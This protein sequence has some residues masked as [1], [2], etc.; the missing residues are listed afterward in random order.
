MRQPV[1]EVTVADCGDAIER[2]FDEG[3]TDGLPVVPPTEPLVVAFLAASGWD[4][5]EVLLREPVRGI[6]VPASAVVVNAVMAG[7][8]P[9]YL[10]VIAAALRAMSHP[11]FRLHIP[12][13][14]TGGAA[15][16]LVVNGPV[17]HAIGLN[18]GGNLFGPGNRANATIGRAI[19][20]VLRNCIGAIPGRFDH[21]TQGWF[22]KYTACIAERE[23]ASPWAPLHVRRGLPADVSAVTVLATESGHNV[24]TASGVDADALL[25]TAGD[26]VRSLG[27]H[28]DGQA[29]LVVGPEH[30][31]ILAAAELSVDDL[32]RRLFEASRRSVAE[33]KRGGRLE[34]PVD[35]GDDRRS[36][37]RG[38]TP[39]DLL[40][41]VGGGDAGCSSAWFPT[42]SRG[43]GSVAVTAPLD[44]RVSPPITSVPGPADAPGRGD[45]QPVPPR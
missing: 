33:L 40:I 16:V 5:E 24:H 26:V 18:G 21:A 15:P 6:D 1:V 8:R 7:C 31:N 23:E 32:Q 37:P 22:G 42:W 12:A 35:A 4:P 28:S 9:D 19:R 14:S 39:D 34:G 29:F 36:R 11:D 17:R 2:C 10:P 13:S 44:P 27:S 38:R 45:D 41:L 25:Y 30:A 20:L 43:R 3:W